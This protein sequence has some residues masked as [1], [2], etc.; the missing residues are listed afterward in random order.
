MCLEKSKLIDQ[1]AV[2]PKQ[3]QVN[4]QLFLDIDIDGCAKSSKMVIVSIYQCP[5]YMSVTNID[6]IYNTLQICTVKMM[7]EKQ[8]W[9]ILKRSHLSNEITLGENT[10]SNSGIHF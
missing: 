5:L 1:E 10:L 3:K 7:L 9:Y 6:L 2:M 8:Y 4:V